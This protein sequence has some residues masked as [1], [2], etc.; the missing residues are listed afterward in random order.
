M[1]SPSLRDVPLPPPENPIMLSAIA[2]LPL[3]LF[4]PTDDPPQ[5]GGFRGPNGTGVGGAH[6]LPET[7]DPDES[8]R[9]RTEVPKGYSSP[10]VTGKRIFLTAAEG[11]ELLTLC[12]DRETGEEVWRREVPFDGKRPGANSPAAPSPVTD[13]ELV[14]SLFH[15]FGMIAYDMD[16]EELWAQELGPFNIPHGMSSSPLLHGDLLVVQADQDSGSFLAAYDKKTGDLRWKVDRPGT[17]HSYTTPAI[18]LPEKGPAEI[19]ISGAFKISSHSLEDGE[20]LWWIEGSGFQPKAVP[21]IVGDRCIVCAYSL[22]STEAGLPQITQTFEEVLE[23]RDEDGDGLLSKKEYPHPMLV[24]AWFVFDLNDDGLFDKR[25]W[26]YLIASGRPTGALYAIR[27]GGRGNVTESHVL[28]KY[29]GR[30]GLPDIASP[31]VVGDTVFLVKSGGLFSAFDVKSGELSKMERI[32]DPDTYYASPVAADGK[33]ITASYGGQLTLL[34]ASR[35]WEVLSVAD[36]GEGIWSTPALADGQII[37]RTQEAVYC[38]AT[39]SE[40]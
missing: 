3:L 14:V 27:L 30:R 1:L 23:E 5:W 32:G 11:E 36:L 17:T 31:V 19:I 39:V 21:V 38:F 34:S 2:L 15:S 8:L 25:D 16:G 7:L 29:D 37:V 18:Y 13:G 4:A 33:V 9:W 40:E 6:P 28:W 12:L 10:I 24:M 20:L 22:P 26:E 35:E